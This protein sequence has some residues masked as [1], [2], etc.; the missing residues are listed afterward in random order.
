MGSRLPRIIDFGLAKAASPKLD[1]ETLALMTRL[2]GWVG[3]P[4]YMSP[5]QADP[6][7]MDVDTRTDVYSLGA[8]LYELLTGFLP[9]ETTKQRFDEVLRRLHEEDPQRPSTRVAT[10]KESSKA[11]ASARGTEPTQ[12]V[13]LLRGDLDWITMKALEKDR[14][15]RYGTPMELAAD[16]RRYLDDK[17]VIAACQ[18]RLS[19]MEIRTQKPDG[20]GL[21]KPDVRRLAGRD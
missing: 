8:V 20:G 15:R 3:T 10:R 17:P 13:N 5:E 18:L 2:G 16:I 21:G 9:F 1:G 12:L 11:S 14:D 7:V 6:A 19:R 4:G